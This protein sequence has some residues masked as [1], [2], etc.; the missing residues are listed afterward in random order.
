MTGKRTVDVGKKKGSKNIQIKF[1]GKG[2][3]ASKLTN[4]VWDGKQQPD[5][6]FTFTRVKPTTREDFE[7]LRNLMKGRWVSEMTLGRDWPGLGE[8][9]F[10]F[11]A[12]CKNMFSDNGEAMISEF[13]YEDMW[14][15]ELKYYDPAAGAVK[16]TIV[17]SAGGVAYATD[18]KTEG[19]W[20]CN[21]AQTQPDGTSGN[22]MILNHSFS[23]D[24][25]T[26]TVKLTIPSDPEHVEETFVWHKISK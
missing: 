19:G 26:W 13:N 8:K 17:N 20:H 7:E 18:R 6:T 9:G 16:T 11:K 15:T 5:M 21:V 23:N 24:G 12:F 1:N 3:F 4:Q 14:R 22:E 10:K 2:Q 25:K